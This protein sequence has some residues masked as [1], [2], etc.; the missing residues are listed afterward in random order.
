MSALAFRSRSVSDL[1]ENGPRRNRSLTH[2]GLQVLSQPTSTASLPRSTKGALGSTGALAAHT[3]WPSAARVRGLQRASSQSTVFPLA[4]HGASR[5]IGAKVAKKRS[6][7]KERYTSK[8][9]NAS[10]STTDSLSMTMPFDFDLEEERRPSTRA[11]SIVSMAR[12]ITTDDDPNRRRT[13]AQKATFE[14]VQADEELAEEVLENLHQVEPC[15]R[16]HVLEAL[17]EFAALGSM[18]ALKSMQYFREEDCDVS[19]KLK[20]EQ[21]LE[22]VERRRT[23]GMPR[24]RHTLWQTQWDIDSFE[25]EDRAGTGGGGEATDAGNAPSSPYS[26]AV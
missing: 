23:R 16:L 19:M 24:L 18:Q 12:Y 25:A 5:G 21:A 4:S 7:S 11:Q 14:M 20:A 6:R 1:S 13:A 3:R 26:L 17:T 15:A 22:E 2:V 9:S 8:D 10:V